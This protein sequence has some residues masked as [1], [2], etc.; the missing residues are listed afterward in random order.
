MFQGTAE[1]NT[2]SDL[3]INAKGTQDTSLIFPVTKAAI[4]LILFMSSTV[5]VVV[6]NLADGG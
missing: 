4:D 5:A 2:A 6:W 3:E 1:K